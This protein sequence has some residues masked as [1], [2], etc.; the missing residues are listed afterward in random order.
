MSLNSENETWTQHS[1][2]SLTSAEYCGL[3]TSCFLGL[4]VVFLILPAV[5]FPAAEMGY[6]CSASCLL[7]TINPFQP[8]S[9]PTS[10]FPAS[11]DAWDYFFPREIFNLSFLNL[12]HFPL[13][14]F[15]GLLWPICRVALSFSISASPLCFVSSTVL[16]TVR[17]IPLSQLLVKILSSIKSRTEPWGSQI[18]TRC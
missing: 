16:M 8:R 10:L 6:L 15:P 3:I 7:G 2:C 14:S 4:A 9:T 13:Y 18:L 17:S 5:C 12:M 1:W 11:M